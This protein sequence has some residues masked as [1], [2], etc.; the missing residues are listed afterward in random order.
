VVAESASLVG[1][2]RSDAL[3]QDEARGWLMEGIAGKDWHGGNVYE[4]NGNI[5]GDAC[6][7]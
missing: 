7:N 6:E 4:R 1:L 2:E 3:F 5:I